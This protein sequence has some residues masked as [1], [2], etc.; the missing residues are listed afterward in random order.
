[1]AS[2]LASFAVFA[3]NSTHPS[4]KAALRLRTS[5]MR[6]RARF[7]LRHGQPAA[8]CSSAQHTDG[9]PICGPHRVPRPTLGAR[10]GSSPARAKKKKKEQ[11]FIA[12]AD[13][14][15]LAHSTPMQRKRPSLFGQSLSGPHRKSSA[16]R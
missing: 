3:C 8:R 1:M 16:S 11:A 2:E 12:G 14:S 10:R 9:G 5:N 6:K 4:P 13:I 7:A 15:E